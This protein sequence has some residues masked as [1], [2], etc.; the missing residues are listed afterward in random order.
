MTFLYQLTSPAAGSHSPAWLGLGSGLGLGLGSGLG[1]G[2]G[3]GLELDG[4]EHLGLVDM[5]GQRQLH[6]DAVYLIWVR[7]GVGIGLGYMGGQRQPHEDANTWL[8]LG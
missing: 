5:V 8:R 1:S 2:L 6:E 3:L 4:L 7:V